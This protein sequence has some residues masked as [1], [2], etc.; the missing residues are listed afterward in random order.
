MQ[1]ILPNIASG[2]ASDD[3]AMTHYSDSA[4]STYASS[5][6]D[7]SPPH[8]ATADASAPGI[9]LAT[10]QR[11]ADAVK[12]L[13]CSSE[14]LV[15]KCDA[16]MRQKLEPTYLREDKRKIWEQIRS[17]EAKLGSAMAHAENQSHAIV[18]RHRELCDA[19]ASLLDLASD[20]EDVSAKGL[21]QSSRAKIHS[22]KIVYARKLEHGA[23]VESFASIK[24]PWLT[25][26]EDV[27]TETVRQGYEADTGWRLNVTNFLHYLRQYFRREPFGGDGAV[28]AAGFGAYVVMAKSRT[29]SS[30]SLRQVLMSLPSGDQRRLVFPKGDQTEPMMVI[31]KTVQPW[32]RGAASVQE[33]PAHNVEGHSNDG[34]SGNSSDNGHSADN[35]NS[36]DNGVG[37]TLVLKHDTLH[38]T[39]ASLVT[40]PHHFCATDLERPAAALTRTLCRIRLVLSTMSKSR[41]VE[42]LV[43]LKE[44]AETLEAAFNEEYRIARNKFLETAARLEHDKQ[45]HSHI[46]KAINLEISSAKEMLATAFI[47]AQEMLKAYED[48]RRANRALDVGGPF[49]P[50]L[51][52]MDGGSDSGGVTLKLT[53]LSRGGTGSMG[54]GSG[55]YGDA[56]A[57]RIIPRQNMV[58]RDIIA[59]CRLGAERE[60]RIEAR[61]QFHRILLECSNAGVWQEALHTFASMVGLGVPPTRDTF[62]LVIRAC[63]RSDP[64]QPAL[65]VAMMRKMRAMGVATNE[66]TFL[67]TMAACGAKGNHRM[68][69]AAFRDMLETGWVPTTG[70]YDSILN[71]CGSGSMPADEAPQLYESLRLGGV[72][73]RIAF[74]GA[75]MCLKKGIV[76]G[77]LHRGLNMRGSMFL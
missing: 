55:Y 30:S 36:A 9:A 2:T 34:G 37:N 26:M 75:N 77:R 1:R 44:Q 18:T 10:D 53:K 65:A 33:E 13:L 25:M 23:A 69:A 61:N 28:A 52:G 19:E 45:E 24:P 72:P 8:A 14:S 20:F 56:G 66:K 64:S 63:R 15:T 21:D 67:L 29:A 54:G 7:A 35:G 4:S 73:E 51:H 48:D 12:F 71:I 16:A 43:D 76:R 59:S 57:F 70:T 50:T 46:L 11:R 58:L 49:L 68:L 60:Q 17:A 31:V 22:E 6:D 74:T 5:D 40:I 27:I 41:V 62:H 3:R 42:A 32:K 38:V 39:T 47:K